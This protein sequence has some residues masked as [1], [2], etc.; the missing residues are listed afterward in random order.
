MSF[1][2]V[3]AASALERG[4][5]RDLLLRL[6]QSGIYRGR[7]TSKTLED[8]ERKL[9]AEM[10]QLSGRLGPLLDAMRNVVPDCM[11]TNYE[12]LIGA[13]GPLDLRR[14]HDV[15]AAIRCGAQVIV[16]RDAGEYPEPLIGKYGI[17]A[18]SADEFLLHLSHLDQGRVAGVIR[19]LASALDDPPRTV[20]DIMDF[21]EGEGLAATVAELRR[22]VDT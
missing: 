20:A 17:E 18:Q 8:L 1:T 12:G 7:W 9:A 11:V 14:C 21:L 10:P 2:A 5:T 15:A 4:V 3:L 19:G 13:M 6:A 22:H 16:T